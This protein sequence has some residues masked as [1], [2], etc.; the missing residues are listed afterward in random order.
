M[1]SA[2]E[3]AADHWY[4]EENPDIKKQLE[5]LKPELFRDLSGLESD[6]SKAI[7]IVSQHLEGLLGATKKFKQFLARFRPQEPL[8]NRPIWWQVDWSQSSL[9][10]VFNK[11]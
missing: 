4:A 6:G 9:E 1:V 2:I 5:N 3:V 10:K 8:S 7:E 11:I